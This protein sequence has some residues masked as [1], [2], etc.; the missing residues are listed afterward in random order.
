[1]KQL[2]FHPSI[3]EMYINHLMLY[4]NVSLQYLLYVHY[5]Y[6]AFGNRETNY[7][8]TVNAAKKETIK[9]VDYPIESNLSFVYIQTG[10][11]V[12][13][14]KVNENHFR[15]EFYP[16]DLMFDFYSNTP[17]NFFSFGYLST[18][19][20]RQIVDYNHPGMFDKNIPLSELSDDP[21]FIQVCH[22]EILGNGVKLLFNEEEKLYQITNIFYEEDYFYDTLYNS[23]GD[24]MEED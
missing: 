6:G 12:S 10:T 7:A 24:F 3:N 15:G 17:A 21:A 2:V 16:L 18:G 11:Q 22:D 14:S 13:K 1:M 8:G 23:I 5:L 4:L 19:Q 20:A 9:F